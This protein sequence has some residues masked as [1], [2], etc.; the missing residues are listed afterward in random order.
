MKTELNLVN[1]IIFIIHDTVLLFLTNDNVSDKESTFYKF[2]AILQ[3]SQPG[4]NL[5]MKT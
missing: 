1:K 4:N 5:H 2:S 3:V